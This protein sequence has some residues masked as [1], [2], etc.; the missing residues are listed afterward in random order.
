MENPAT[1]PV[2]FTR[3][4]VVEYPRWMLDMRGHD[5]LV[6]YQTLF[7]GP[8]VVSPPNL[9]RSLK[10]VRLVPEEIAV[11]LSKVQQARPTAARDE[12]SWVGHAN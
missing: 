4:F 8:T 3:G 12:S 2:K 1:A 6:H 10:R 9:Y 11:L 5:L 7:G